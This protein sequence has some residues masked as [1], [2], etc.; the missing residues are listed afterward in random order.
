VRKLIYTLNSIESLNYQLRKISKNRGPFPTDAAAVK[1]LRL[2]IMNVEDKRAAERARERAK[3]ASC[4][5]HPATTEQAPGRLVE[6]QLVYGWKPA[7]TALAR[8]FP[9]DSTPTSIKD[10]HDDLHRELDNLHDR[11][12]RLHAQ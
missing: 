11:G 8:L 6:G 7:L 2:A 1:L 3:R 12:H 10:H 5:A 9:D 4:A